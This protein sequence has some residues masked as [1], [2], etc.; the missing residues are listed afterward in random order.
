MFWSCNDEKTC[1]KHKDKCTKRSGDLRCF[2]PSEIIDPASEDPETFLL[3]VSDGTVRPID[4][5]CDVDRRRAEETLRVFQLDTSPLL[6]KSRRDA[7]EP[8]IRAVEVIVDISPLHLV[9]YVQSELT[10]ADTAPFSAA[11]KA[12]LKSVI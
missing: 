3:F 6:R 9:P 11:I 4:G 12:F 2:D 5:L 7:V 8:L 1:G 10:R